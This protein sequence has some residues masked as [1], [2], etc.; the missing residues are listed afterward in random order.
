[1]NEAK[2]A[3]L[4]IVLNNSVN[5]LPNIDDFIALCLKHKEDAIF[6]SYCRNLICEKTIFEKRILIQVSSKSMLSE[7]LKLL[8]QRFLN[9][10]KQ[11]LDFQKRFIEKY[12]IPVASPQQIAYYNERLNEFSKMGNDYFFSFTNRKPNPNEN[13]IIHVNYKNFIK[14]I[15]NYSRND[16]EK[17]LRTAEQKNINLLAKS[18]NHIISQKLRGFYFPYHIGDNTDVVE[19]LTTN[20]NSAFAFVQLIQDIIFEYYDGETN[21]CHFEYNAIKSCI[22]EERRFFILAERKREDI[23]VNAALH[24]SFE[25]WH[26]DFNRYDPVHLPFSIVYNQRELIETKE[27]IEDKIANRIKEL[28]NFLFENVPD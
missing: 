25:D 7:S 9:N 2:D 8:N 17:I 16:F 5:N 27:L 4:D 18:I 26:S 22:P 10:Q 23:R 11:E 21:Y 12:V 1:M 15:L 13:N 3:L 24:Q 28:K 6:N 20:C 19:K 14:F